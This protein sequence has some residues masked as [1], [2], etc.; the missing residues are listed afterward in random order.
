MEKKKREKTVTTIESLAKLMIG[1]FARIDAS[2]EKLAVNMAV[3]FER[4]DVRLDGMDE[5]FSTIEQEL[6]SLRREIGELEKR[7]SA[8][9]DSLRD[10]RGYAKEIDELRASVRTLKM[11]L[12]RVEGK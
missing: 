11:R 7:I 6:K 12:A 1:E 10:V 4:V 5:H 9:E 2:I 8:F 3:E